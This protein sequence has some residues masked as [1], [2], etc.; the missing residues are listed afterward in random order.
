MNLLEYDEKADEKVI[1]S[2]KDQDILREWEQMRF[3]WYQDGDFWSE[4]QRVQER[5]DD[6]V[7][8]IHRVRKGI[9]AKVSDLKKSVDQISQELTKLNE[10]IDLLQNLNSEEVEA[11]KEKWRK[12]EISIFD[13]VS[14]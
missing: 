8:G 14:A 7:S 9:F 11:T 13:I 3:D 6:A 10:R 12:K 2:L 4:V 5:I 1:A